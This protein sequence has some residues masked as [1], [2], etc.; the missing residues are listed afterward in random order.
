MTTSRDRPAKGCS[1]A[2]SPYATLPAVTERRRSGRSISGDHGQIVDGTRVSL[3]SSQRVIIPAGCERGEA[4]ARSRTGSC[5]G[6]SPALDRKGYGATATGAAAPFPFYC[7]G[8]EAS[9][10]VTVWLPPEGPS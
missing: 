7:G 2:C 9:V 8:P 3:I 5:G 6:L 10:T 1:S 4:P